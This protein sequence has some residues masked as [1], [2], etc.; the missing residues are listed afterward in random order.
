MNKLFQIKVLTIFKYILR[1]QLKYIHGKKVNHVPIKDL[2]G[3]IENKVNLLIKTFS[4]SIF[5]NLELNNW[6]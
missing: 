1:N 6:R 4:K 3:K 5:E 2:L